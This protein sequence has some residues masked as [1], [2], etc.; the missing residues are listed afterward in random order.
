MQ[1]FART[2][3]LSAISAAAA[4][5]AA[6]ADRTLSVE[7]IKV[8]PSVQTQDYS[9][10]GEVRARDSVNAAFTIAGRI[11]EVLVEEGQKVTAGAVLARMDAV[12]QQQAL[13]AAEAGLN[14]ATADERQA[15]EDLVRAEALLARGATTRAARDVAED[16]LQIAAGALAQARAERDRA[17][18]ALGDTELTAPQDATVTARMAEAGQVVGAAQPVLEL[19]LT[20]GFEAVFEVPE[21]LLTGETP[22]KD[23]RLWR[24]SD[25]NIG[26]TGTISEISPL[27]DPTTGTVAVTVQVTDP[28]QGLT[29]GE[30]VRGTATIK[31]P[32]KIVLPYTTLS[33]IGDGPAVWQVDPETH[34]VALKPIKVERYQTGQIVVADGIESGDQI[35][36]RGAQLLYPG[37][38]VRAV[39][40]AP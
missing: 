17:R 35:V 25:P 1:R 15:D 16:K 6:T 30:A 31:E 28:P 34:T 36:A 26:F 22:P 7:I 21:V 20:N 2:V 37:R 3:V 40:V 23:I 8:E 27:V 9:L 18:K 29:Y 39:G 13:R 33:A 10:T 12:Q 4:A 11:V 19:A 14:T 38:V 32:G 24:L 5:P